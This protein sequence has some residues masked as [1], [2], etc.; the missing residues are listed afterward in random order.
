M[1]SVSDFVKN[2]VRR[3]VND[4]EVQV[5]TVGSPS[6][7]DSIRKSRTESLNNYL[8]SSRPSVQET[9]EVQQVASPSRPVKSSRPLEDEEDQFQRLTSS[10]ST[11]QK[12]SFRK[13]SETLNNR[14]SK[15]L[16][17]RSSL[18][19]S[20]PSPEVQRT[21]SAPVKQSSLRNK[22]QE[23]YRF[24]QS[25][26][27]QRTSYQEMSSP[28]GQTVYD[29]FE[30]VDRKSISQE[31]IQQLRERSKERISSKEGLKQEIQDLRS[32]AQQRD[33]SPK[34]PVKQEPQKALTLQQKLE[35]L[36]QE[37]RAK[38]NG[39]T[40]QEQPVKQ[41][42]TTVQEEP[43][44]QREG[45]VN[46]ADKIQDMKR[47]ISEAK[48]QKEI[49]VVNTTVPKQQ[50][51]VTPSDRLEQMKQRIS[52]SIEEKKA[53]VTPTVKPTED[54]RD[55]RIQQLKS[56][57]SRSNDEKKYSVKSSE[58][59]E[60]TLPSRQE[61]TSRLSAEQKLENLKKKLSSQ[62]N[63]VVNEKQDR[64]N[65]A[66]RTSARATSPSTE[67]SSLRSRSLRLSGNKPSEDKN[68]LITYCHNK[69]C[70]TKVSVG[71]TVHWFK[72]SE[73]VSEYDVPVAQLK[74]LEL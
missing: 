66:T 47:R 61:T 58:D 49:T 50:S 73:E 31:R 46:I 38:Q 32:S 64:A 29:A 8:R 3:S 18:P 56:R 65:S 62:Q 43:S 36:K 27:P 72:G 69:T 41:N 55:D 63:T 57:L 16:S 42:T 14:I 35:K 25:S 70:Y 12:D 15:S 17:S 19:V 13:R 30:K 68:W 24:S 23:Q 5:Q 74:F 71:G 9:P 22:L 7:R 28:K 26:S 1:S 37:K 20:T 48:N 11:P 39:T 60:V 40:V 45:G 59:N 44:T 34:S 67:S 52:K 51:T 21:P 53:T 54:D 33:Q 10:V 4:D 6:T 2:S